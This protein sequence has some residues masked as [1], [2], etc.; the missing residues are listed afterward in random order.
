MPDD[1]H[2]Y[3]PIDGALIATSAPSAAHQTVV[4]ELAVLLR[5][6]C[7]RDMKVLVAPFDVVLADDTIMQPDLPGHA[8]LTSAVCVVRPLSNTLLMLGSRPSEH[9]CRSRRVRRRRLR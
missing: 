7:P 4:L 6:Q 8:R 2:R 3:E 1:G 5:Q 9:R